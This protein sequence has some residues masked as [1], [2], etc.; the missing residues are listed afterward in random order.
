M[1]SVEHEAMKSHI[2]NERL[3]DAIGT[4]QRQSEAIGGPGLV[5]NLR[6]YKQGQ[7]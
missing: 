1:A 2:G 7:Y 6:Q 5:V 3:L 4:H